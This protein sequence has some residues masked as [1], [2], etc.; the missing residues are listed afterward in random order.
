MRE[1]VVLVAIERVDVSPACTQ[2]LGDLVLTLGERVQERGAAA[3]VSCLD[4]D[5]AVERCDHE[6]LLLLADRREELDRVG[7][8]QGCAGLFESLGER[9]GLERDRDVARVPAPVVG[10]ARVRASFEQRLDGAFVLLECREVQE[11]VAGRVR[12]V[13]VRV[14]PG[15]QLAQAIDVVLA[16]TPVQGAVLR[17]R[18]G[19]GRGLARHHDRDQLLVAG[20]E[21]LDQRVVLIVVGHIRRCTD[22]DQRLQHDGVGPVDRAHQGRVAAAVA[23]VQ[24]D[25]GRRQHAHDL[26]LISLRRADQRGLVA[27][28][29]VAVQVDAERDVGLHDLDVAALARAFEVIASLVAIDLF[30]HAVITQHRARISGGQGLARAHDGVGQREPPPQRALLRRRLIVGLLIFLVRIHIEELVV[31]DAW[32]VVPVLGRLE[33]NRHRPPTSLR[34]RGARARPRRSPSRAPSM[35]ATCVAR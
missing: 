5:P 14:W 20:L 32:L 34:P 31:P 9:L 35:S 3:P 29:R 6:L 27:D 21:R 25:A 2:Q 12:E 7:L 18:A 28:R 11:R 19:V 16:Q 8:G 1:R 23:A 4:R 24:I 22:V 17:R 10:P 26:G 13:A 15:K 30:T 33:L